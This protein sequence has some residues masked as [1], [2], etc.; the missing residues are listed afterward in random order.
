MSIY[1]LRL[2]TFAWVDV[3]YKIQDDEKFSIRQNTKPECILTVRSYL[4]ISVKRSNPR[5]FWDRERTPLHGPLH[6][7]F[8]QTFVLARPPVEAKHKS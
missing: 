5:M 3:A 7:L 8:P 1:Q 6:P 2:S 4:F